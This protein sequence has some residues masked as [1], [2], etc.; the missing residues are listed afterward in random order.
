[1]GDVVDQVGH[2]AIPLAVLLHPEEA[3]GD[4]VQVVVEVEVTRH[5]VEQ[6]NGDAGAA[7]HNVP[8][9]LVQAA[10]GAKVG[11]EGNQLVA[12][13]RVDLVGKKCEKTF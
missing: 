9:A 11:K 8:L 3:V 10:V 4:H 2:N 12:A 6:V 7:L 13:V 1:M 5:R